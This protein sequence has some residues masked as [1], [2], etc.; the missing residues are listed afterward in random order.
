MGKK[1]FLNT[2]NFPL[3][4]V[5]NAAEFTCKGNFEKCFAAEFTYSAAEITYAQTNEVL[6]TLKLNKYVI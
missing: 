6:R 5:E 3:F 2:I 1:I 4:I